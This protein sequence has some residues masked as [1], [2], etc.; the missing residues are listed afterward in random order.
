MQAE[1][2]EPERRFNQEMLIFIQGVV[3]DLK[4]SFEARQLMKI[5][6]FWFY[7]PKILVIANLPGENDRLTVRCENGVNHLTR[8]VAG[9]LP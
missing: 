1:E 3:K 7:A 6:T 2:C 4:N 8:I 5:Y 9:E